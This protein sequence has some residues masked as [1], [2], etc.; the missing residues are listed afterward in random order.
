MDCLEMAAHL[1]IR[2]TLARYCRGIDRK[3][4]T[5]LRAAF[6]PDCRV[7]YGDF[8]GSG[9][10]FSDFVTS[11]FSGIGIV[12]QH[13]VTNVY[14]EFSGDAALVESYFIVFRPSVLEGRPGGPR[15]ARWAIPRSI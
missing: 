13:H 4:A 2:Q 8:V 15:Q 14:I 1:S 12:G 10:E 11:I 9:E 6:H 7:E 3:D 5:I